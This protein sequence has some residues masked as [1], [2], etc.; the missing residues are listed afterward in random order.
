MRRRDVET[1][2]GSSSHSFAI[3]NGG[4]RYGD[5]DGD[6]RSPSPNRLNRQSSRHE[7]LTCSSVHRE[8]DAAPGS[9][10]QRASWRRGSA[11]G[12]LH[13]FCEASPL[14]AQDRSFGPHPRSSA[15][16]FRSPRTRLLMPSLRRTNS[17]GSA[18][19]AATGRTNFGG[20]GRDFRS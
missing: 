3:R 10:R 4:A 13:K 20:G 9:S 16:F 2:F 5:L 11:F 1:L 12:I 15:N 19:R 8:R 17:F 7:T 14:P 18:F 6:H